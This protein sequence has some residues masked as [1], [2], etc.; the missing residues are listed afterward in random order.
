MPILQFGLKPE[1][2]NRVVF[3]ESLFFMFSQ[4][5]LLR[6]IQR[7]SLQNPPSSKMHFNIRYSE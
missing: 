6:I 7:F 5:A 4:N 2:S 1:L 3:E